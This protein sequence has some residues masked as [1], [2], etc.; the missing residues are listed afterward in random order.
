[1][2]A[3]APQNTT[4]F[5]TLD[6]KYAYSQLTIDPNTAIHCIFN[7]M[8]EEMTRTYKFQTG[9]YGLTDMPAENQKAMDYTLNGF[10]K[11]LIVSS[12]IF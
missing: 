10:K 5:L 7:I 6:L 2:S 1:M 9:F 3:P 12:T 8:S 4:Y 11:I